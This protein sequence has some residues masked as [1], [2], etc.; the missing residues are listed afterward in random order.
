MRVVGR[1]VFPCQV[2]AKV[3]VPDSLLPNIDRRA[4][5][6]KALAEKG[7]T[8]R[9][10][11]MAKST[12]TIFCPRHRPTRLVLEADL[13]STQIVPTTFEQNIA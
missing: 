8:Y 7:W 4:V 11:P 10:G 5:A 6:C 2:S 9:G 3:D 1:C 12:V 13:T